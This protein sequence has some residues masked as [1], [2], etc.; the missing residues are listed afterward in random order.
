MAN[1]RSLVVKVSNS[2]RDVT[3]YAEQVSVVSDQTSATS[4]QVS[5]AMQ[6]IARSS[7]EQAYDI[8]QVVTY[9]NDLSEGINAVG[10]DSTN[11]TTIVSDTIQLSQAAI[12]TVESN[13]VSRLVINDILK[14]NEDMNQI[15]GIVNVINGITEQTNLLSL[16]AAI[17]AA[18]AGSPG[19]ALV[20]DEVRKLADQSRDATKH[21][22]AILQDILNKTEVTMVQANNAINVIEAQMDAVQ[23]TNKAFNTIFVLMEKIT[24]EMSDV[25]KSID[26][27]LELKQKSATAIEKA[28]TISEATASTIQE[29]SACSE[30]QKKAFE[31]LSRLAKYMNEMAHELEKS[32]AIFKV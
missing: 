2:A 32:I 20:A 10:K 7:S 21:I 11:V 23:Q 12:T 14:L 24:H 4:E 28:Y 18:R 8:S 15:Q 25:K 13:T 17:E 9:M 16:N 3:N 31:E 26:A 29:I 5:S 27:I 6:E 22:N 30:E 1:I 19:F